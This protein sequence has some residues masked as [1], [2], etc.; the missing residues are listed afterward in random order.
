[1]DQPPTAIQREMT[2]PKMIPSSLFRR[3]SPWIFHV[4]LSLNSFHSSP[5][6][7]AAGCH[8]HR[9]ASV[10]HSSRRPNFPPSTFICDSQPTSLSAIREP[11][12]PQSL[13]L[14][15]S[16][17]Q[18]C[19]RASF[20]SLSLAS[21]HSSP[22]SFTH[23]PSAVRSLRPLSPTIRPNS[24]EKLQLLSFYR[25]L[26]ISQPDS[27]RDVL[28][29]RLKRIPGLRGT[30]Y[31]AKEGINAQFAVPVGEPLEDLLR[32][33][34]KKADGGEEDVMGG[35][36]PFDA[37]EKNLPNLGN[38]VDGGVPT[39]DRLIV[40]TRDCILRDGL[41]P[42]DEKYCPSLFDWSDAGVELDASEW[43][44]QLRPLL[45]QS[46]P[47]SNEEPK[48]KIQL[49]DCRNAYES[50]QGTFLSAV[51]LNTR[52]FSETWS[53]LD[54]QV[55]SQTLNP[56]EPVY[57]FCTGGIRCVKV[58]AYLKQK[59][60]CEDVRSLRHGIIG[61]ER[62]WSGSKGDVAA[63]IDASTNESESDGAN[64]LNKKKTLWVGENFLF[65]K[66]RFAK[67]DERG[68]ANKT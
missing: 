10:H 55:E 31:V 20:T 6:F 24:T 46:S 3:Q 48:P 5:A 44:A 19:Q 37:F 40:R 45:L 53:I 29:Q 56:L 15:I 41:T 18:I 35:C 17:Q 28:F 26:P 57:I 51:P 39:F 34:G 16:F 62:W 8:M 14:S 64:N 49:L 4:L 66:R 50:D 38:V 67:E 2:S 11:C 33:F 63:D 30:V 47:G 61:Y 1:M 59:L 68:S 43:D 54:S 60:G 7:D 23:G 58:G 42:K 32:A 21:S 27:L 25:F 22:A 65:D 12:P 9:R 13:F 36:L 52:T